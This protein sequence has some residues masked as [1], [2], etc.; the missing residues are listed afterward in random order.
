MEY[1]I[2]ALIAVAFSIIG[3][4]AGILVYRA[5]V[6]DL[7]RFFENIDDAARKAETTAKDLASKATEAAKASAA[8]KA[9]AD[10]YNKIIVGK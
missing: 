2:Y 6:K 8:M 4:V 5:N 3:A 9:A 10:A 7:S 1:G